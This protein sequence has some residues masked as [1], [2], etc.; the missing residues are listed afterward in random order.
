MKVSLT[1]RPAQKI[2]VDVHLELSEKG[3]ALEKL[4][5]E[6][7]RQFVAKSYAKAGPEAVAGFKKILLGMLDEDDQSRII[8]K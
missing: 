8:K 6:T 2:A 5:S 7:Q 1:K 3:Y 4:L